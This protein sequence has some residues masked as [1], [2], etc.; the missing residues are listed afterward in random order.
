MRMISEFV[1][2][3][4]EQRTPEGPLGALFYSFVLGC[5]MGFAELSHLLFHFLKTPNMTSDNL[6]ASSTA[7]VFPIRREQRIGLADVPPTPCPN[8]NSSLT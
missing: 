7:T 2:L 5:I 4:P 3:G 1:G 8:K 6:T